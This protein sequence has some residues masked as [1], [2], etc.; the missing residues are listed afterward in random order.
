MIHTEQ[1]SNDAALGSMTPADRIFL[2]EG[3]C[4]TPPAANSG[5]R[6]GDSQMAGNDAFP[7]MSPKQWYRAW[8]PIWLQA[9]KADVERDGPAAQVYFLLAP[10]LDRVKIGTTTDIERRMAEIGLWSP[11]ALEIALVIPGSYATEFSMHR[12][13]GRF[14]LHGEWFDI[15]GG[16]APLLDYLRSYRSN[17]ALEGTLHRISLI[18]VAQIDYSKLTQE[19]VRSIEEAVAFLREILA[20][21]E[22][23]QSEDG[24]G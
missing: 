23:A 22:S 7:M 10:E 19:D 4:E 14:R 3:S 2:P 18:D 15:S 8:Y 20:M 6:A 12:A 9:I 11:C 5:R 13:F 1:L 17:F 21:A 24:N 16:G